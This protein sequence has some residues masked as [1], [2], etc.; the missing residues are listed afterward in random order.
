MNV[1]SQLKLPV[2]YKGKELCGEYRIDL[3][4]EDLLIVDLK[5][6]EIMNPVYKA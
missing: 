1:Q 4:I 2:F 6:V 5:A 3:L